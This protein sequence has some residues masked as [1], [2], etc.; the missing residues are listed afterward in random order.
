M[1]DREDVERIEE[2]AE[3]SLTEEEKEELGED[4][5]RILDHFQKLEELDTEGVEPLMHI[6][7]V[8]NVVR[9]DRREESLPREEALKNAPK[10]S[11][12]FFQVPRVIEGKEGA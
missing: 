6:L 4:L 8:K 9:E 3:L 12:G 2:L 5:D 11:G 7:D 1:I 10:T